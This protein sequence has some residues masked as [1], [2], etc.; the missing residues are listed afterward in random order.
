MRESTHSIYIYIFAPRKSALPH[1][2]FL[3]YK[4]VCSKNTYIYALPSNLIIDRYR[5]ITRL[6]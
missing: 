5:Y 6:I 2:N 1:K 3:I 4:Y